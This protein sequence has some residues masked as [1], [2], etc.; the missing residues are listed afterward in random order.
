[1]AAA[2]EIR[3][4]TTS[5]RKVK[6]AV[7]RSTLTVRKL[8]FK[9][10]SF[11]LSPNFASRLTKNTQPAIKGHFRNL[12]ILRGGSCGA[13]TTGSLSCLPRAHVAVLY[14]L[15]DIKFCGENLLQ[16]GSLGRVQVLVGAHVELAEDHVDHGPVVVDSQLFQE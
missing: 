10:D 8:P 6:S 11:S 7:R 15:L 2:G 1:M 4:D 3:E 9:V 16:D 12:S 13:F 14:L 5:I